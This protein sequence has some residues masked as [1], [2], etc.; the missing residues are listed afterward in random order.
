[1]DEP[2][3]YAVVGDYMLPLE[4]A[5]NLV[6]M[7]NKAVVVNN[8]YNDVAPYKRPARP[9]QIKLEVLTTAQHA[10]VFLEEPA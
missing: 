7:L 10:A 1:M 2:V 9:R 6:R 3:T 4:E 8:T 5:F